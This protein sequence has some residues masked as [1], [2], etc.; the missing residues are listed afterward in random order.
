[1]P[2]GPLGVELHPVATG[3]VSPV[4]LTAAPDGTDRLFVVEQT[5]YVRL[6]KNG[7]LLA[8]PFLD[9]H[10]QIVTLNG[11]YDE[12]GLLGL[13]FHPGYANSG[14]P[15]YRTL[16]TYE[17]LPRVG[18]GDFT[19][20]GTTTYNH[21]NS[22]IEW[23]VSAGNADLV[24][25]ASR[26]IL[27]RSDHPASNHACGMIAFGPDGYLYIGIGDG[28]GS[29][30]A[31]AGHV[32]GGNGQS[33]SVVLGKILR[34]D[35]LNPSLTAG[36][37]DA[38]SGNGQ[39]RIPASN[40]FVGGGGLAE[41]YAYGLRNPYR[42]SFDSST[43][44]LIA[45]DV[46]QDKIEEVDMIISGGNFGWRVKEGTFTFSSGSVIADSPGVPAGLID[47]VLQYDH[48]EGEAVVGGYVYHGNAIPSQAGN[49]IFGDWQGTGTAGRLFYGNLATGDVRQLQIGLAPRSLGMYL[50]GFGQD[51]QG[52]LY[53]VGSTAVGPSG[54]S[55]AVY[56][57]V[58]LNKTGDIDGNGLVNASD[59]QTFV[60]AWASVEGPPASAN[61]NASA[62][63]DNN[64]KI[65]I[66]D[67]QQLVANWGL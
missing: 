15:G 22:V 37:G 28:G 20:P 17:S 63:I 44:Q 6:I 30:D 11:G 27:F 24:D 41:I 54:T 23:K 19:V 62:D 48:D 65:N 35:P 29:N 40:P 51:A 45:A 4:Y 3:L 67:L 53:I 16:Y 60:A 52:E 32:A 1:M 43:G 61:W 10:L 34:I 42:F 12:R 66:G 21:Q 47:P 49:Y 7:T 9:D 31:G 25:P 8:Q 58:K 57:I 46:G 38:A 13:A 64:G 26:R 33:T 56:K 2:I 55:G 36:S 18:T 39:Y 50:K 59:L 5:G 14:S